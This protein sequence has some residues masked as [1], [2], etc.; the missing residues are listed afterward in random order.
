MAKTTALKLDP[1]RKKLQT[2]WGVSSGF[3]TTLPEA[4]HSTWKLIW[5]VV[6]TH[7]KNMSKLGNL[8]QVGVK[9]T[10]IWNHHLVM[11]GIWDGLFSKAM[12]VSG[13]VYLLVGPRDDFPFHCNKNVSKASRPTRVSSIYVF[14]CRM[15]QQNREQD[16]ENPPLVLIQPTSV[17]H[18]ETFYLMNNFMK[19]KALCLEK[20]GHPKHWEYDWMQS[21]QTRYQR[22]HCWKPKHQ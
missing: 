1:P 18:W 7:L 6:S 3:I 14:G 12:L 21:C 13:R 19:V 10:N 5:L 9:I 17:S 16:R 8:P 22:N 15:I 2:S 4:N 11:V 20:V